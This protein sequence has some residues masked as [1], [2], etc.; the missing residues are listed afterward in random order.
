MEVTPPVLNSHLTY[1]HLLQTQYHS[2]FHERGDLTC[3]H[4]G[5]STAAQAAAP[6]VAAHTPAHICLSTRVCTRCPT[7][8]RVCVTRCILPYGGA[9]CAGILPAQ[10]RVPDTCDGSALQEDLY[11]T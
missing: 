5:S 4:V 2:T 11:A 9:Q 8:R 3:Y 1:M 7:Y 6:P 10:G